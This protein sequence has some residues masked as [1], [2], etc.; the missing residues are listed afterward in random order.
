MASSLGIKFVTV[1]MG[2]SDD[3]PDMKFDDNINQR[4]KTWL[5]KDKNYVYDYYMGKYEM[6][7]YDKSCTHLFHSVSVTTEGKVFPCCWV[8]DKEYYFGDLK[9]DTFNEVWNNKK[10]KYSRNLFRFTLK[11]SD[12]LTNPTICYYCNNYKKRINN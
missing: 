10:Y 2:L 12:D 6:P 8:T 4:K 9:K 7:L 3:L 1:K 5:P 11:K